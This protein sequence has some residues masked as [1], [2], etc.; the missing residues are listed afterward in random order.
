MA[1]RYRELLLPAV[2]SLAACIVLVALGNWQL[3]RLVWKEDLIAKAAER[4]LEAAA[5]LPPVSAWQGFDIAG[6][7][8]RPFQLTGRFLHDAEALVFT[9]L[10]DA[11]GP[12]D[13][14]GYWV[15]TPFALESGGTV[16]VNRGFAPQV[17]YRPENRGEARPGNQVTVTGLLR[18]NDT[19]NLFTPDDRPAENVFFARNV[20]N[21]A[22]AKQTPAPVAPFTIDLVAA[23]TPRGGLPQAGETRMIFTNNHLAYAVTWYGLAVALIAVFLSYAWTRLHGSEG[24]A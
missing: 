3:R 10:S 2:L 12:F 5:A 24:R 4:P 13:G 19:P 8:F 11:K 21:L 16:F 17:R 23:E 20:Q 15:V 22:A 6:N 14:P 7:E 9:S 18:P 1:P